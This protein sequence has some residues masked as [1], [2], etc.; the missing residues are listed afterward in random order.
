MKAA[1]L[2]R[3]IAWAIAFAALIDP[4]V[5]AD[6]PAPIDLAIVHMRTPSLAL[7]AGS[8]GETR[9][10]NLA[11]AVAAL[12]A[13]LGA[14]YRVRHVDVVADTAADW[15][16][17]ADACLVTGDDTAAP[18]GT[19]VSVP[20]IALVTGNTLSPNVAVRGILALP[21]QHAEAFG[22]VVVSLEGHGV[23]GQRTSVQLEDGGQP[24]G[25][26]HH[27]WTAGETRANLELQWW[28]AGIGPRT[29]TVE[30]IP[31]DDERSLLDNTETTV[32]HVSSARLPILVYEPRPSWMSTFV[33]RELERDPR[34]DIEARTRVS[35]RTSVTTP[36]APALTPRAL[37]DVGL[38]IVGGLDALTQSDVALLRRFVERRG[39]SL[40][41][42]PDAMPS[43]PAATLV[44]GRLQ[45][46]LV[47]TPAAVGPLAA[48]EL[49]L[50]RDPA[51]VDRVL[52]ASDD[53]T[54]VVV[55]SP[56]GEGRIVVSGAM[57]AWRHRGDGE[58]F[59]RFW[60]GLAARLAA[61][62]GTSFDLEPRAATIASG[63]PLTV[64]VSWRRL[65]G[66]ETA[67]P[68]LTAWLTCEGSGQQPLTVWPEA[69]PGT[70]SVRVSAAAPGGCTV[71]VAP[72]ARPDLSQAAAIRVVDET[73]PPQTH[74]PG[75]LTALARSRG[76]EVVFTD[77]VGPLVEA[78]RAAVPARQE[79]REVRPLRTPW[80][81]VLFA[82]A[83]GGEWWIRRR[84]GQR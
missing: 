56:I 74:R 77:A 5:S 69:A 38:V 36:D 15:C 60:R 59:Q 49:A 65:T 4:V 67:W 35:P 78:V 14:E 75:A 46:R 52:A 29:L 19:A 72:A 48:T 61:E 63:Q 6:R 22:R 70:Y 80:W 42:L 84:N 54:A 25:E 7:P 43:G 23:A 34:L 66:D 82:G 2:L 81:I 73:G 12:E 31:L 20:H 39:G 27:D 24:R 33:R 32:V 45:E 53:G 55:E 51:A 71:E 10:A 16:A 44:P 17:G 26:A 18:A 83:L 50:T 11:G 8:A 62:A 41:L 3:G 57:D 21:T 13:Q 68:A 28:P 79:A 64:G 9:G 30:A 76:G 37:E 58:Q 1:H 47:A 40:L